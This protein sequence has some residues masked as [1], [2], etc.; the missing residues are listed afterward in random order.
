[1]PLLPGSESSYGRRHIHRASDNSWKGRLLQMF[2]GSS[3]LRRAGKVSNETRSTRL[4]VQ[5]LAGTRAHQESAAQPRPSP[6]L[7]VASPHLVP[8]HQ[9]VPVPSLSLSCPLRSQRTPPA[10]MHPS[11]RVPPHARI[12]RH[13]VGVDAQDRQL[14]E[15]ARSEQR[16]QQ[17]RSRRT[18]PRSKRRR[19]FRRLEDRAVKTK[20]IGCLLSGVVLIILLSVCMYFPLAHPYARHI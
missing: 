3:D 16:P 7:S 2:K 15:L 17:R 10:D 5:A 18:P 1:M 11:A 14:G 9:H 12:P 8:R 20:F 6:S 13:D 4:G 19:F